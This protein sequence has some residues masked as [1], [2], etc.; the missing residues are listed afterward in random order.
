MEKGKVASV[1]GAYNSLN[2]IP[3]CANSYLLT[4]V[5]RKEWGFNGVVISDGSAIDKL[6]THHKYV[7]SLE[8]G[9]A[10]A[11]KAGCDMSLRDEYRVGLKKAYEKGLIDDE[12]LSVAAIRVI[13]LRSRLGLDTIYDVN[14][15]YKNIPYSVVECKKHQDLALEAATK[16][17]VLL[18]NDGLLP[19]KKRK[20]NPIKIALIGDAFRTIY[21]GDYSGT[22]DNNL[23]LLDCIKSDIDNSYEIKW[24]GERN[25]EV[26]IPANCLYRA[27]NH[28]YDGI[29]GFSSDYYESDRCQG[30]ISLS[31]QDLT[32]DLYPNEDQSIKKYKEISA[33]WSSSLKA[34][35]SG[36]YTISFSAS[37]NCRIIIDGKTVLQKNNK[38]GFKA[39]FDAAFDKGKTYPI[40]I[41]C[42]GINKN[43]P[44]SLTWKTP[45]NENEANPVS[46]AKQS[47]V[48]ILFLRDDNSSEGRDRKDLK[49]NESYI[50]L[51][52]DVTS[53]NANT[54]LL[55]GG[56]TSLSLT[57]ISKLPKSIL[58]AWIGGQG[59]SKAISNILFGKTNPSG[60]IPLTFYKDESQLPPLDDYNIKNGRSYEYFKG[61]I[62]YPFGYGLSYTEFRYDKPQIKIGDKLEL[63]VSTTITNTGEYDGDEIVQCYLSSPSWE[64][65]GLIKKLVGYKRI[66]IK[67]GESKLVE[68]NISEDSF[69]RWNIKEKAWKTSRGEFSISLVPHS[70]K[71]NDVSFTY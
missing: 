50:E 11:L 3:C 36:R 12:D 9:A 43:C 53:A 45:F 13:N 27:E 29:L 58:Y 10:M 59:E 52:K 16:S 66:S 69:K 25:N 31:R 57:E 21:Y 26:T 1:M 34:P 22:P 32:L 20:D 33:C 60:K 35:L 39:T 44:I 63:L 38:Q 5:L 71:H 17:I 68:F 37:G 49:L 41:I 56:S 2:G 61:D 47:D 40:N 51:I 54:I 24:V 64:A 8:E 70:G 46:L 28:A 6:Y 65:T 19:L 48:A 7:S 42:E 23:T 30:P 62:L 55:L 67:K 4:D 15:P 14:N 18:K